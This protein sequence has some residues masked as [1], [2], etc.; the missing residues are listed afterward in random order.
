MAFVY[1][2]GF[3]KPPYERPCNTLDEIEDFYQFLIQ[4]RDEIPM[5]M[6]GMVIKVDEIEKQEQLGYTVKFPSR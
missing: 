4:K 2:Q 1:A 5:M 6:D 3:L